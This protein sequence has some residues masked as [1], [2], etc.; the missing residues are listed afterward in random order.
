MDF[1][2]QLLK[3]MRTEIKKIEC[4]HDTAS[5]LMIHEFGER[6]KIVTN[7]NT[8]TISFFKDGEKYNEI[9]SRTTVQD[10]EQFLTRTEREVL[11]LNGQ[12]GE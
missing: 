1:Y 6:V 7:Y 3:Q 2:K 5:R 10:F 9:T 8:E 12:S 11:E 4:Y